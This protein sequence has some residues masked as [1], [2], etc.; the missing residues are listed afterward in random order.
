MEDGHWL[1]RMPR[2]P[3]AGGL[4]QEGPMFTAG[5]EPGGAQPW[6]P[7]FL[8]HCQTRKSALGTENRAPIYIQ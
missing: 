5:D 1:E 2:S 8:G 6:V 3:G 4:V 7:D